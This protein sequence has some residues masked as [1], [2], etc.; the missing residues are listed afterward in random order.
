MSQAEMSQA[1]TTNKA[2]RRKRSEI[3]REMK[4]LSAFALVFLIPGFITVFIVP[5]L[6]VILMTVGGFVWIQKDAHYVSELQR[7]FYTP[8]TKQQ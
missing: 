3:E 1:T 2:T 5:P 4:V 8:D 6:G 7:N